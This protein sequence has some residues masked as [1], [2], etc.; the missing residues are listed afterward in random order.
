MRPLIALD[1][2]LPR[3]HLTDG[4]GPGDLAPRV[5]GQPQARALPPEAGYGSTLAAHG[6]PALPNHGVF[7]FSPVRLSAQRPAQV[8]YMIGNLNI[9]IA[10]L[11][12]YSS[13]LGS[14]TAARS[15]HKNIPILSQVGP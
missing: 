5:C 14:A 6:W 12:S 3:P 7:R 4:G 13:D 2:R 1:L 9:H 11:H 8:S 15:P 10:V